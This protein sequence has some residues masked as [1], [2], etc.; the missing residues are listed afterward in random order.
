MRVK[1]VLLKLFLQSKILVQS[2]LYPCDRATID[3]VWMVFYFLLCP[4]EYANATGDEQHP[5]LWHDVQF[6]AG[7]QNF[8]KVLLTTTANIRVTAL[9]SLT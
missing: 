2:S 5:L 9:V 4:G 3:C 6:K 8:T 1:P 7:Y